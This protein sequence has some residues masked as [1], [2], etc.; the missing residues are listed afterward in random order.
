MSGPSSGAA[1]AA[2][3]S[4]SQGARAGSGLAKVKGAVE[5]S[6]G[7]RGR[8]KEESLSRLAAKQASLD[9]VATRMAAR[10]ARL[11]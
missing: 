11:A 1:A 5:A 3:A 4:A 2:A 6:W 8:S 10:L 9:A 7:E